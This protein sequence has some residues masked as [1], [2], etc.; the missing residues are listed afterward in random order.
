MQAHERAVVKKRNLLNALASFLKET[1]VEPDNLLEKVR[2]AALNVPAYLSFV[3]AHGIAPESFLTT[4]WADLPIMTKENYILVHSLA[5]RCLF[6]SLREA[7]IFAVSSGTTG[8]PT[9]WPRSLVDELDASFPYEF[10]IQNFEADRL[11][12]LMVVAF[13]LGIWIGGMH[14]ISTLRLLSTKGFPIA[15]VTPGA[16]TEEIARAI[17]E[18]AASFDQVVLVGYPPF[19]RDV[20]ASELPTGSWASVAPRLILAGESFTEEW[21]DRV[22]ELA[23]RQDTFHSSASVYGTADAG[24]LAFETPESIRI[25]RLASDCPE[26]CEQLFRQPRLPALMQYNGAQ[27]HFEE[28]REELL[29]SKIS[30]MP[31]VRYNIGDQGGIY[32]PADLSARLQRACSTGMISCPIDLITSTSRSRHS[33]VY[34]FGRSDSTV[35]FFGA[36]IYAEHISSA[37][38][39]AP[40]ADRLT[41]RFYME[42]L[43]GPTGEKQLRIVVE[44]RGGTTLDDS[45][46][47][48]LR[49]Y[50]EDTLRTINSEFKN[51]VPPERQQVVLKLMPFGSDALFSRKGK[52][53]YSN[54]VWKSEEV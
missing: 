45:S 25:R 2:Q 40:T 46:T 28:H 24:V 43:D 6:G 15:V 50:I 38:N 29:F 13:P 52:Q 23:G 22:H 53:K 1:P 30:T 27:V 35:S 34:L 5:E 14:S 16:N 9:I 42:T 12:T 49:R 37:I 20:L 26:L 51:Y 44:T 39:K 3:S 4:P 21:R 47:E 7:D 11:R 17:G 31:L 54:Q 18:L 36:N 32:T 10:V 33:F 48:A 41:G 8:P 19:L